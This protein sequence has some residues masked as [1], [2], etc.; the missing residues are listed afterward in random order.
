MY[1]D[2]RASETLLNPLTSQTAVQR[3]ER[4]FWDG[5]GGIPEELFVF[6]NALASARLFY[7]TLPRLLKWSVDR[8]RWAGIKAFLYT[9]ALEPFVVQ[10]ILRIYR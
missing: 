5:Y 8:G 3:C 2:L 6:V 10:R 9:R 1:D 4:S 7:Y